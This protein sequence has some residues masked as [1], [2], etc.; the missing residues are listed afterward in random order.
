[1][2][3]PRSSKKS[4]RRSSTR[5]KQLPPDPPAPSARAKRYARRSARKILQ[6][7]STPSKSRSRASA[8]RPLPPVPSS[9]SL[10]KGW[11]RGKRILMPPPAEWMDYA[12]QLIAF[13]GSSGDP[14]W[15]AYSAWGAKLYEDALQRNEN[16]A[17]F[18]NWLR[19]NPWEYDLNVRRCRVKRPYFKRPGS[20]R[21]PENIR[22]LP[23]PNPDVFH[24]A[25]EPSSDEE[26]VDEFFDAPEPP[27]YNPDNPDDQTL[28]ALAALMM[29][30]VENAENASQYYAANYRPYD[31]HRSVPLL[32]AEEKAIR[33]YRALLESVANQKQWYNIDIANMVKRY[34]KGIHCIA[35]H[36]KGKLRTKQRKLDDPQDCFAR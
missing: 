4:S 19:C 11:S 16:W 2:P 6:L 13:A 7:P 17:E 34:K 5:T 21:P 25:L 27:V 28:M 26:T 29:A 14:Y 31:A 18:G 23:H 15:N 24:D 1:M 35:D 8:N 20:I 10:P 30:A 9:S 32:C 36:T 22:Y 33:E 3:R 12:R